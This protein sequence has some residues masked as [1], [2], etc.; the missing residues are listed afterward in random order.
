MRTFYSDYANHC[1]RFYVRHANPKFK[2][3]ADKLNWKTSE[4]VFNS[5]SDEDKETIKKLYT[6]DEG[7]PEK[8]TLIA[9]EKGVRP[10]VV[11]RFI[12]D[13][14]RKVAKHRGLI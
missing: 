1:L 5:Y 6:G 3:E 7:I 4:S 14:E 11:W 2:S 13:L 12:N 8:V 10:D 9:T